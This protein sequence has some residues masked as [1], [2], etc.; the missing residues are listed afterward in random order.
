MGNEASSRWMQPGSSERGQ[1]WRTSGGDQLKKQQS[2][3]QQRRHMAT[4]AA[5]S[6][7]AVQG[8]AGE[9]AG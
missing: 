3:A 8:G 1:N 7:T 6:R 2:A 4:L 5:S 9:L